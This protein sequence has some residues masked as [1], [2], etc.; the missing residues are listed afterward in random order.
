MKKNKV[1]NVKWNGKVI[2]NT[3]YL[4]GNYVVPFEDFGRPDTPTYGRIGRERVHVLYRTNCNINGKAYKLV[5]A[6]DRFPKTNCH[7]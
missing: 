5:V 6:Y 1:C 4:Q 2:D 3:R 7:R